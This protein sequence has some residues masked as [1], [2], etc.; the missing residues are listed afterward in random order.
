M[1]KRD[2]FNGFPNTDRVI[3]ILTNFP[4]Q[5][6]IMPHSTSPDASETRVTDGIVKEDNIEQPR[7]EEGVSHVGDAVDED[8]TMVDMEAM[9]DNVLNA[10][11]EIKSEVKLEDLFADIDSDDE[12]S[13]SNI[14][15]QDLKSSGSQ[16]A[17]SSPL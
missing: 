16:E 2:S 4:I 1:V 13:S 7:T 15:G 9:D 6:I 3:S 11:A 10:N 5:P 8:M 14:K 17:P 12:S